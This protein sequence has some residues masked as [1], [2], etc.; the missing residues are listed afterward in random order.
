MNQYNENNMKKLRVAVID[1]AL[2]YATC[3]PNYQ[4]IAVEIW[5]KT[6]EKYKLI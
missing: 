1:K 5:M 6:A 2:P 3:K 4:G